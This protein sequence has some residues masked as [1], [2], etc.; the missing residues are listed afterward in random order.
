MANEESWSNEELQASVDTYADMYRAERDGR[1]VNKA[2]S[3]RRLEAQFGRKDKA[4]ER[5]MMN[6][7]HVVQLLGGKPVT[8]LLPAKNIGP[9]TQSILET[10][11]RTASF[12]STT[13]TA[14]TTPTTPALPINEAD[15][16][17]D[18]L[19]RTWKSSSAAIQPPGG[20][21][22]AQ[23]YR[24][25]T[26]ERKRCAEV[27]AWVLYSAKGV[28]GSCGNSAPFSKADGTPYLEVHHVVQL[29]E[30]GPDTVDNAVAVCP[31]CHRALHLAADRL[32]LADSLYVRHPRLKRPTV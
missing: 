23:Q 28:C 30:D 5:R 1:R 7:S 32:Q 24:T 11:I 22:K 13:K 18:D 16:R 19:V 14:V 3:Y 12:I 9:H 6:I 8:G 29:A 4:F 17:A 20:Y 21:E 31:N 26:L 15:Q 2:E 25:H 10:L 27:K